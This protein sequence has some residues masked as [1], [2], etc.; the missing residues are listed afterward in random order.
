[1]TGFGHYC[2]YIDGGCRDTTESIEVCSPATGDT[3]DDAVAAAR[4][5]H[6]NGVWRDDA[7]TA[8]HAVAVTVARWFKKR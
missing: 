3:V 1:M 8:V 5:A 4:A 6:E 2:M 7:G